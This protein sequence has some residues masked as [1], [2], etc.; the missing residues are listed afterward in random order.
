MAASEPARVDELKGALTA[1]LARVEGLG[2]A[3]AREEAIERARVAEE[4]L[5][6]IGYVH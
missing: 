5:K 2:D 6:A 3:S 4:H 1:W